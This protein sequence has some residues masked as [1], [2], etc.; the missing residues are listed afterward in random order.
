MSVRAGSL[1][2]ASPIHKKSQEIDHGFDRL[3]GLHGRVALVTGAR[4]GIGR[5]LALG[6]ASAGARVICTS[7]DAAGLRDVASELD[8]L[9]AE[10]DEISMEASSPKSISDGVSRAADRWGALDILINN[11]GVPLRRPALD[12]TVEEW[13]HVAEVN[14]R[15]VFLLCQAA[16]RRM[17]PGASIINL[18]STFA[19]AAAVDRAAYAAAKAAVEQMTRVLALEWAS[20]GITVNAI[21]PT[22]IVTESRRELF[23]DEAA[24]ERRVRQIPLG[25]LGEPDDLIGAAI[26][27]AGPAGRFITG[28]T[29]AVDGGFSLGNGGVTQ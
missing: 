21:A 16:A 29:L 6:L 13:D 24:R 19:R 5:A 8:A 17:Q 25:R 2:L 14:V 10:H 9:G 27:L 18:S 7:R 11:A 26:L 22:T 1:G 3:F 23:A 12:I 15:G 28:T 4:Q 20:R